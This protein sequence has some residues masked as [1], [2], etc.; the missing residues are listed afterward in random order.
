MFYS[1]SLQKSNFVAGRGSL[2]FLVADWKL[3]SWLDEAQNNENFAVNRSTG[4]G[5]D[6]IKVLRSGVYFIYSNFV[7]GGKGKDCKYFLTYGSKHQACQWIGVETVNQTKGLS[8]RQPCSLG[9][10]TAL[11][12]G[13]VL[14]IHLYNGERCQMGQSTF[15][16]VLSLAKLGV[17][18]QS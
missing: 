13:D 17:I 5:I 3:P 8:R 11:K 14:K 7:F 12:T 9:F 2:P 18:K 15:R 16:R 6:G 1:L 10:T 4:S